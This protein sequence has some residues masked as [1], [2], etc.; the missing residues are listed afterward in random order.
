MTVHRD[1]KIETSEDLTY[2]QLKDHLPRLLDNLSDRLCNASSNE[3]KQEAAYTAATHGDIR[4]KEGYD[5]SELIREFAD[6]R[7]TIIPHLIQFQE[8]HSEFGGASR[9][10]AQNIVHRFLDNAIRVSVEQ[11]IVTQERA[12][13]NHKPS[14]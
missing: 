4:W 6:L 14:R 9:L 3:L 10:F 2:V 13:P 12:Q 1:K 8:H 7:S 11:F 5:V